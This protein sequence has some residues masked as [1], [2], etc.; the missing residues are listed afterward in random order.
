[1]SADRQ[2]HRLIRLAL[3]ASV[4]LDVIL[5]RNEDRFVLAGA[6]ASRFKDLCFQYAAC[7]SKLGSTYHPTGVWL[8]HFTVKTHILLH[9]GL[10]C[11]EVNPRIA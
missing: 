8:F 4:E 1:M 6:D 7:V 2:E 5:D 9:I 10:S 3:L 11:T